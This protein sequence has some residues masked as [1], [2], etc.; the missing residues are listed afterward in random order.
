MVRYLD[1]SNWLALEVRSS[2]D[3]IRLLRR[4]D[5]G[6][7]STVYTSV[8]GSGMSDGN[9]YNCKLVIGDDPGNSALQQLRFWV[10]LNNSG[11][12]ELGEKF[13]ETTVVANS[14]PTRTAV[15]G[16]RAPASGR[17]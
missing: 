9:W 12:F 1:P 17:L 2:D 8:S 16:A 13:A 14:A 10:D 6:A 4:Q 7:M 5:D 11:S 3:K 15:G